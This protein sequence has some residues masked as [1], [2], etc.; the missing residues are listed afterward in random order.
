MIALGLIVRSGNSAVDQWFIGASR[1]ALGAH[2]IWMLLLNRVWVLVSLL[3]LAVGIALSRRQWRLAAVAALCPAISIAGAKTLKVLFGRP[4]SD[5]ALAYPSG[6]TTVAITVVSM[7][8]LVIGI[9]VWTVTVGAIGAMVPSIGMASNYFHY[10]T[11]II[12]GLL[13]ATSMVCLAV[14]A[15]GPDVL[16]RSLGREPATLEPD[17]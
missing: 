11:D 8:V 7:L 15:A 9:R 4:W 17:N 16:A 2:P 13:Y 5:E 10:F 3:V 14:L 12:G 1:G 6:H